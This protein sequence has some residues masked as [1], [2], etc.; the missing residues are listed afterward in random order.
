M[1]IGSESWAGPRSLRRGPLGEHAG[2]W[3]HGCMGTRV[4]GCIGGLSG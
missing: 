4:Y 1:S 2:A 3:A